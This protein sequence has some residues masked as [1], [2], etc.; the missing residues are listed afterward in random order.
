MTS[1][2]RAKIAATSDEDLMRAVQADDVR[3]FEALYDRNVALA[4]RL[5]HSL[6]RDRGRAEEAV[7][8]AF[9]SAWRSRRSYRRETGSVRAWLVTIVRNR[10]LDS[11]R[12]ESAGHR[13]TLA[14]YDYTG[15]DPAYRS[16]QDDVI[17]YTEACGLRAR[18]QRLPEAQAE[19]IVLA[20]YGEL[21][22]TEIAERLSLPEGTVKGRMRLGLKK[23]REQIEATG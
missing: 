14:G 21:T 8:D 9:V 6:C 19:V 16:A 22:H 5:A 10:A 7:Q 13:P 2:I 1:P 15:P 4:W 11:I 23:L 3:A 17:A 20:F 18:L 12:R